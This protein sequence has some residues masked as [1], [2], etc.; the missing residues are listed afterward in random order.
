MRVKQIILED[1]AKEIKECA[2]KAYMST[3]INVYNS[4]M[5]DNTKQF[6]ADEAII[7]KKIIEHKDMIQQLRK[8]Q[9]LQAY[10]LTHIVQ[11]Y[12]PLYRF[13]AKYFMKNRYE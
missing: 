13:Y 6:L 12:K 5:L 4:L 2:S 8:K 3:L 10:I 9:K 1:A 7:R 11:I